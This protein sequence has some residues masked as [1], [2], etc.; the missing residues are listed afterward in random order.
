M[1]WIKTL[2][3]DLV[4]KTAVSSTLSVV[5]EI[6][7]PTEEKKEKAGEIFEKVLLEAGISDIV[8]AN[9]N[10]L[11]L[12]EEWYEGPP[13]EDDVRGSIQSFKQ[14]MGGAIKAKL[15]RIS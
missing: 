11:N 3:S 1:N 12:Y 15:S 14:E 9:F 13:T 5:E 6:E 8:I 7:E 4:N 10:M 2:W